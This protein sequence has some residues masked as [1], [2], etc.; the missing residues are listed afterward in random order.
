MDLLTN[1]LNNVL[2]E[3]Q[4][5]CDRNSM[6]P[7]PE[8]CKAMIMQRKSTFTSP[9]QALRLS[10]KVVM[11]TG[12]H[13]HFSSRFKQEMT[14]NNQD[15]NHQNCVKST[16]NKIPPYAQNYKK[17]YLFIRG[18]NKEFKYILDKLDDLNNG[19][20]QSKRVSRIM[21][22]IKRYLRA[23][24]RGKLGGISEIEF[25]KYEVDN[26][27]E[28]KENFSMFKLKYDFCIEGDDGYDPYP[29]FKEF[30]DICESFYNDLKFI[31][32][33][34]SDSDSD[35]DCNIKIEYDSDND[36]DNDRDIKIVLYDSKS[37]S[38]SDSDSVVIVI[39]INFLNL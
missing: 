21:Q 35:N 30:Y 4:E 27:I 23:R 8:K 39:V 2:A 22:L 6:V 9:I 38:E 34:D 16:N 33:S 19:L 1:S 25:N 18:I 26:I 15:F 29:G 10:N 17:E 37:D 11:E 36:S 3:L 32:D 24:E 12:I 5:W 14:R 20:F 13:N 31:S 28:I 7:H